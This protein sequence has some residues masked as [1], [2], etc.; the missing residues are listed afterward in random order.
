MM[1]E[2]I[3]SDWY[4]HMV[5]DCKAIITERVYNSRVELI[6]GYVEVGERIFND[7]NYKKH[8]RGNQE[9]VDKLFKDIGISK[10]EGYRCLQVYEKFFQGKD[11]VSAVPETFPEG[12]NISWNKIIR[13]HLPE[14]SENEECNHHYEMMCVRCGDRINLTEL[15]KCDII[16]KKEIKGVKND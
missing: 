11:I 15:E 8:S 14:K 2:L 5:E 4:E 13:Y 1:N 10:S 3:V 9:F 6:T 12:K 16:E 7:E